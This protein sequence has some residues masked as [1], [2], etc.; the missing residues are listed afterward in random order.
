[1]RLKIGITGQD[2]FIGIN[3]LNALKHCADKF[4]IINF[5]K[6]YFENLTQ[7][8]NF[9]NECDVIIHA[10]DISRSEKNGA[11]YETNMRLVNILLSSIRNTNSRPY[12][13]FSSSVH[14]PLWFVWYGSNNI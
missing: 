2:G 1:M 3:I 10:A 11:V 12:I 14:A 8:E 9:V 6:S 5:K 4:E 13:I 7:M